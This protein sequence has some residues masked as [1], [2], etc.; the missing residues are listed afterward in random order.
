M[1][2]RFAYLKFNLLFSS[3]LKILSP[4]Y[5]VARP[6]W[7]GFRDADE[8]ARLKNGKGEV[9]DYMQ[10]KYNSRTCNVG[11]STKAR[12]LHVNRGGI[13]EIHPLGG[14]L[15]GT[16][17]PDNIC[18]ST[19]KMGPSFVN[20]INSFVVSGYCECKFFGDQA[21]TDPLLEVFNSNQPDLSKFNEGRE[22]TVSNYNGRLNSFSCR[23]TNRTE[24]FE[25][26]QVDI[27]NGAKSGREKIFG[28][29]DG[30]GYTEQKEA[31]IKSD[32]ETAQAIPNEG[33]I[34]GVTSCREV[35]SNVRIR[36]W[37]IYGC[38]CQFFEE[39][40]CAG[41]QVYQQGSG[42]RDS[43]RIK[44]EDLPPAKSFRC[45]LPYG[46]TWDMERGD[47]VRVLEGAPLSTPSFSRVISAEESA[48]IEAFWA[49]MGLETTGAPT[50]V[51]TTSEGPTT[52][53]TT[54][55]I[56]IVSLV[57]VW[58]QVLNEIVTFGGAGSIGEDIITSLTSLPTIQP[59]ITQ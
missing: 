47:S 24:E 7:S 44:S 49:V 31:F 26:C 38:T 45:W 53:S 42:G 12:S 4:K 16:P 29:L 48:A 52:S 51:L 50:T 32:L 14:F 58:S 30:T 15:T 25:A 27:N 56:L 17:L 5:V 1:L 10:L 13:W 22:P 41:V 43:G 40:G 9:R 36:A 34:R 20:N 55:T 19:E 39:P 6:G 46:V 11:I 2:S 3:L 8:E 57:T 35:N 37:D 21:C 18:Y 33:L 23:W 54:R 59:N 28:K